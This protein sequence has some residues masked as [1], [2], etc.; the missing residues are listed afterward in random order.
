MRRM[1]VAT[2]GLSILVTAIAA[3]KPASKTHGLEASP[4]TIAYGY[5]WSEANLC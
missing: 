3:Q 1:I 4:A 2:A 5:Y